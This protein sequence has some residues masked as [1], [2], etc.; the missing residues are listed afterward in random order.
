M[1]PD[2]VVMPTRTTKGGTNSAANFQEKVA[3]CFEEIR[4]NF[5][6]WI[7]DFM[8]FATD[9]TQL[10]LILQRFFEICRKR[11]LVVSLPKSDFFSQQAAWCERIIDAE[12]IRFNPKNLSGLQNC[13]PPRTGGELCEYVHGVNWISTSIPRFAE[14]TGPLCELLEATYSKSGSRKKRSISKIPLIDIGWNETHE[15]AFKDL[16]N[17]IQESTRLIHRSPGKTLFVHTDASDKH[18]AICATQCNESELIKLSMDQQY[19]PSS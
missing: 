3:E 7:D 2:G 1:T 18:W 6:A 12:G 5:K 16:Q 13:D 10:L 8:I 15:T 14:R 17:Q 19:E 9:E 4:E 11:R